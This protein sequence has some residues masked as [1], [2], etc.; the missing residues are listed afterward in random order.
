MIVCND[1]QGNGG[2][3]F[4]DPTYACLPPGV[5]HGPFKSEKGC[6]LFEIHYYLPED[7]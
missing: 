5:Y 6:L 2:K 1:A 3:Q 4:H 7:R